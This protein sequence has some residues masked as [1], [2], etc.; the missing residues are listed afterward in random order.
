VVAVTAVLA[1][2]LVV[3]L[4]LPKMSAVSSAN[5]E[6][7][8]TQAQQST[9]LSQLAALQQAQ[10]EAEANRKIIQDVEQKIPPTADEPEFLRLLANAATGAGIKLWQ[11]TPSQPVLNTQTNL[12]EIPVTFTVKGSY[13]ALAEY[14]YNV[15]TLPRVAKVQTATISPSGDSTTSSS[16][17]FLQ[18]TG[19]L[20]LYTSDTSAGPGSSPGPSSG[21]TSSTSSPSP[22]A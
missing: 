7:A 2:L 14:L 16:V 5:T 4:V 20:I 1:I 6:L 11:F 19:S 18:M 17:P 21:S 22:G 10:D 9:L 8:T 3:I 13:F 12:S 15:E